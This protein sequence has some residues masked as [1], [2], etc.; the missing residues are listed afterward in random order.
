L[1]T[2]DIKRVA[3]DLLSNEGIMS[4]GVHVGNSDVVGKFVYKDSKQLV[5]LISKVKEFE[6]IERA[7]WSEEVYLLPGRKDSSLAV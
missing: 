5:D 6:N 1:H 2:G 3:E 4:S 7:V